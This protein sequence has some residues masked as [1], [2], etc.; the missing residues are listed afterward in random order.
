MAD[1]LRRCEDSG[2]VQYM[3]FL[4]ERQQELCEAQLAKSGW[5]KH[6]FFGGH[7]LAE[8]K[9]LAV[10]L[11]DVPA[12]QSFPV[13]CIKITAPQG[14]VLVH[15]DCLGAL[16][17]LGLRRE[18]VGDILPDGPHAYAFVLKQAEGPITQE[19]REVG[20][21]K[22]KTVSCSPPPQLAVAQ[23]QSSTFSVASLRLDAILAGALKIGREAAVELVRSGRVQIN[24][25]LCTSVSATLA[26]KDQITVRGVG[27]VG[28]DQVGGLSKKGRVFITC[29]KY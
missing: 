18:L 11:D 19:L 9:V 10:Y 21:V 25:Q 15:R 1:A 12:Q 27:R 3:G 24:H 23:G 13:C 6:L 16:L 5:L 4:D 2:Q 17:G 29:I 28:V 7:A 14:T 20:P 26:E 8:R 22:V